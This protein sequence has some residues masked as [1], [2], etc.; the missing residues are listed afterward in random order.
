MKPDDATEVNYSINRNQWYII[1][2]NQWFDTEE[3]AYK[4]VEELTTDYQQEQLNQDHTPVELSQ[5]AP[6]LLTSE[7]V[8]LKVAGV[9]IFEW[10]RELHTHD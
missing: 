3:E 4:R 5:T 2:R 8:V 7:V 9:T 6:V 1:G 10:H